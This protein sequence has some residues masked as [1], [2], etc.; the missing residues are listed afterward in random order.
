MAGHKKLSVRDFLWEAQLFSL[1]FGNLAE[2][3]CA[4]RDNE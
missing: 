3:R 1:S 4:H 2:T